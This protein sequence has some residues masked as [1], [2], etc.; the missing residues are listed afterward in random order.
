VQIL[1]RILLFLLLVLV[2]GAG[3]GI[4]ADP[5]VTTSSSGQPWTQAVLALIYLGFFLIVLWRFR[6]TALFLVLKERWTLVLCLWVAASTLWSVGPVESLRHSLALVGTS[7]AGL[8]IG[9]R[10]EPKQQL[11]MFALVIGL[12]AIASLAAGLLFPGVGVTPDGAWQGIYFPKNSLGRIM[13]LGALCFALLA[14][15]QRRNRVVRGGMFFL[16]CALLLLSRSATAVVVCLLM[17]ALFPFRRILYLRTR[18][19]I[20]AIVAGGVVATAIVLWTVDHLDQILDTLGRTSSLT[21]RIPLWGIVI[22][23]IAERPLQGYGFSAFWT[24]WEGERVSDTVAWD[25]AVPNA[26]NGFLEVWLGIGLIGLVILA[27]GMGRSF[28]FA[29]RKARAHGE[30]D[31]SWPLILL[32]FLGL[33]NLTE[34]SLLIGNSVLWMAYVANS[35]WL[36]RSS[37]EEKLSV[38]HEELQEPAYSA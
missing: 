13:S 3:Q 25:V 1:E 31:Q 2:T 34:T 29:L 35:F 6:K 21:G 37:A 36:V 23:E 12:G 27:I 7:L 16:C 5:N 11:K 33:Y 32:V 24:S 17:F 30:F 38:D 15:S 19:L 10:Y 8:Y 20:G 18:P 26:H 9:M 22:K 28:L 4:F 14:L